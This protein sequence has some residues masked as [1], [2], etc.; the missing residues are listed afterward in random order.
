MKFSK[1]LRERLKVMAKIE[2]SKSQIKNLA[3]PLVDKVTEF[4]KNPENEE[5]F[6]IW[7]EATYGK[8]VPKGA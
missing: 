4:Y 2:L 6:K 3:T 5:K 1:N 8:P 7:Y